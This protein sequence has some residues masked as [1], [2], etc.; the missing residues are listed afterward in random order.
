M[1]ARVKL[2]TMQA[3][4][5]AQAADPLD[6]ATYRLPGRQRPPLSPEELV[7]RLPELGRFAVV[8]PDR[9]WGRPHLQPDPQHLWLE[10]GLHLQGLVDGDPDLA[11]IVLVH[12]TNQLEEIA[13]FLHL[14]LKSDRPV[15]ITGS[16]RPWGGIGSDG[17]PNLLSAV[18]VAA[19][20][21]ARGHGVLVVLN[22]Q[23]HSAR[24]VTKTSTY[25]LEAFQARDGGP[26]GSVDA[27]G[28]RF[29]NR[30]MTAHTA[31]SAFDLRQIQA[32]PRVEILYD[33]FGA[34][35]SLVEA[36]LALGARGLVIAGSGAGAAVGMRAALERAAAAGVAV[37]RASRVGS[38]RV[39]GIDHHAFPGS[40][41]A[42]D[43]NPQKARV[44]LQLALTQTRDPASIQA[45]FDSH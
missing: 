43:L 27:G 38:G 41:A 35:G 19:D 31:A 36:V 34:D 39:L 32:L 21:A 37:V 15:V 17:P 8:E 40:I 11:G 9:D 29:L 26:L 22:E 5:T 20:P 28:V 12:G 1:T 24:A 45:H 16:Q 2:V 30:V 25:G 4:L 23:I 10:V 42:G 18:R 3:T 14:T 33:H 7:S 13:Y 44:L 6:L